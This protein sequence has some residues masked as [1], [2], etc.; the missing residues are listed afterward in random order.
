MND[1]FDRKLEAALR[2]LPDAPAP[3]GLIA[4]TLKRLEQPRAPWLL[5]SN[6][7][8]Y[9]FLILAAALLGAVSFAQPLLAALERVAFA[10]L[11]RQTAWLRDSFS[12]LG[13][14]AA[15]VAQNTNRNTLFAVAV[16]AIISYLSC[17]GFGTLIFRLV[18][19][20]N[21]ERHV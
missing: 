9:A 4:A 7:S 11:M 14:A 21:N 15:V 19:V 20:F 5:W 16:V 1:D 10:R 13:H 18:S 17:I 8:R 6:L 3:P 12:S 2:S